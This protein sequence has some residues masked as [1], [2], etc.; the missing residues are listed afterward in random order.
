MSVSLCPEK[1]FECE[2]TTNERSSN[3]AGLTAVT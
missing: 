2:E 3:K 1:K